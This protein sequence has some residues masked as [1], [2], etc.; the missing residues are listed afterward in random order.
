MG[1]R[2]VLCTVFAALLCGACGPGVYGFSRTY[3]P[4]EEEATYDAMSRHYTYGAVTANPD[5]FQDQL[6][7]WF[8][9]I[10]TMEPTKDGRYLIRFAHHTHKERHLCESEAN[11]SCRVTINFTPSGGFSALL[12]LQAED[13][14]PSLDKIQPGTLMRVF[15]KV[16]CRENDDEEIVCDRDER[17]GVLFE[18][19]YYRQWPRRY[20]VTTRAAAVM[21]R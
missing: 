5:D 19:V 9:V 16:R 17:G 1:T 3:T 11:D 4:L 8:G 15:G 12:E 20:Y 13:L 10:E 7:A 14:V 2:L 21:T 18:G 6:I